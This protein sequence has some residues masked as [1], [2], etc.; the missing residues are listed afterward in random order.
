MSRAT[1]DEI[2]GVDAISGMHFIASGDSEHSFGE[3][4]G[5]AR[6]SALLHSLSAQYDL[7]LID[8]PPAAIVADALQLSGLVDAAILLVK[9]ASTP[10]YLVLDGLKKLRAARTPLVGIVMTQVDARKY[11]FYGQGALPYDYAKSY[12][13]RA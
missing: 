12:Y 10:S 11:K 2:I 6:M 1:L 7:V 4:L 5:S 8:T 13:T 3:L 9:W